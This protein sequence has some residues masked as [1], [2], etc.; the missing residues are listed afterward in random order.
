MQTATRE[1][2]VFRS[3]QIAALAAG[4]QKKM[5]NFLETFYHEQGEEDSGYVT[6]KYLQGIASQVPGLN[7]SQWSSDR[8]NPEFAKQVETDA[9]AAN[10]AGFNGT[11]SFLIGHTGGTMTN[12][13][14]ATAEE[15][16]FLDEAVEK[17]LKA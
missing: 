9:Q 10:D 11:P 17:L 4:K 14:T 6:E 5:W 15:P 7:L 3:Q 8:S 1:P 16:A 13:N 2:E 12:S